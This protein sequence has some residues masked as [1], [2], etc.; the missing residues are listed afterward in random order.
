MILVLMLIVFLLLFLLLLLLLQ[1]RRNPLEPLGVDEVLGGC[2][3]IPGPF[4]VYNDCGLNKLFLS[5]VRTII[6][7]MERNIRMIAIT[8]VLG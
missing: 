8:A 3:R 6:T 2:F 4:E 5:M 1:L 7:M